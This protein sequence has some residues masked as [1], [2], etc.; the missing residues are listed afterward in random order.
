MFKESKLMLIG[1]VKPVFSFMLTAAIA[2][3][4]MFAT[5]ACTDEEV[6]AS[7]G[8]VAIVAGVAAV[9]SATNNDNND[10]HHRHPTCRG[11]YRQECTS[12]RDRWGNHRRD[13]REVYDSCRDRYDARI[14]IPGLALVSSTSSSAPPATFAGDAVDSGTAAIATKYGI[15]FDAA[16]QLASA[17]KTA[18]GGD[19]QAIYAIGLSKDDLERLGRL[20]MI[21][22]S[23]LDHL[24]AE[25]DTTVDDARSLVTS[26]IRD[27]KAQTGDSNSAYWQSCLTAKQWK[28][29]R[30]QW[31]EQSYWSGCSLETGAS[32][33]TAVAN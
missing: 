15:G 25:L 21:T 22:D 4:M 17:L 16:T 1:T 28:T 5:Q 27:V 29:D 13:C 7:I 23:G 33:C 14:E 10:G 32:L 11:G 24:A 20:K 2:L 12:F 9:A 31:C 19:L 26:L 3:P 8:A 6:A 30:N 18:S